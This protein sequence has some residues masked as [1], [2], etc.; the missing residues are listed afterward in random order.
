MKVEQARG[1]RLISAGLNRRF[2]PR[3]LAVRQVVAAGEIGRAILYKG[4][5]RNAMV[6]PHSPG[7]SV[8]TGSAIHDIDSVRWLLGQEIREVYVRG[9]RTHSSF[10]DETLDMLLL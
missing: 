3:H 6:P 1:R 9:V 5:H 8:V 7:E 10:S 2:D 4:V